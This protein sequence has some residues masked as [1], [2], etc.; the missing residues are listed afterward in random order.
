VQVVRE[1]HGAEKQSNNP[2]NIICKFFLEA[3]EKKLYGEGRGALGA[4]M[5]P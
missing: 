3:V 2:T 5:L 1:K 4:G